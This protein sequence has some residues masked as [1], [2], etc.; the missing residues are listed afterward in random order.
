VL[1]DD[2]TLAVAETAGALNWK[3]IPAD[4]QQLRKHP[5]LAGVVIETR[6]IELK[7]TNRWKR[8]G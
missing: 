6:S 8:R 1:F 4:F 3:L 2:D 5:A 7:E